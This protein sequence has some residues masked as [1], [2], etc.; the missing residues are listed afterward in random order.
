MSFTKRQELTLKKHSK[1][2]T[3]KHMAMMIKLMKNGKT[4]TEAHKITQKKIGT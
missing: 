4:F 3:P 2:H 1:H